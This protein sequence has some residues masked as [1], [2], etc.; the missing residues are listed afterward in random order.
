MRHLQTVE[1]KKQILLEK[2]K[3]AEMMIIR[4]EIK[5][6]EERKK[7]EF[8]EAKTVLQAQQRVWIILIKFAQAY[9]IMNERKCKEKDKTLM[10]LK[11][12]GSARKLQMFYKKKQSDM[13]AYDVNLL[14]AAPLL[15]LYCSS[16]K[17][18]MENTV[19]KKILSLVRMSARMRE[20]PTHFEDYYS[21]A[22][23]IQ[24]AWA[25]YVKKKNER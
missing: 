25:E 11:E 9:E 15:K 8:E 16:V 3:R 18:I 7:R 12:N 6:E 5:R 24:K 17:M 23:K 2:K 1:R 21:C 4:N 13:T 22:E 19:K 20:I 14:R 10:K